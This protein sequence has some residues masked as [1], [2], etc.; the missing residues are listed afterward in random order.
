MKIILLSY[1]LLFAFLPGLAQTPQQNKIRIDSC[2]KIFDKTEHT[3]KLIQIIQ[4]TCKFKLMKNIGYENREIILNYYAENIAKKSNTARLRAYL[5]QSLGVLFYWRAERRIVALD[6][7]FKSLPEIETTQDYKSIDISYGHIGKL[8]YEFGDIESAK[9]YFL[10]K[11][12]FQ[13]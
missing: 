4:N 8:F 3:E 7:L 13:V 1:F 6:Y 9:K 12:N 5:Y 2:K 11:G 10:T